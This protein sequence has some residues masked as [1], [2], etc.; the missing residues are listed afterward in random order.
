M[1]VGVAVV[2]LRGLFR[3]FLPLD[4]RQ[5]LVQKLTLEVPAV[6][7]VAERGRA[8]AQSV[9]VQ[10]GGVAPDDLAVLG[11]AVV[12]EKVVYLFG[13]LFFLVLQDLQ[14]DLDLPA[15]LR[16]LDGVVEEVDQ[17]LGHPVWV[18]VD[19]RVKVFL[20]RL[21]LRLHQLE[22]PLV[23]Y[24]R[25][26]LKGVLDYIKHVE[27]LAV[28][29]EGLLL[30]LCQVKQVH[31]QV[32]HHERAISHAFHVVKQLLQ[33]RRLVL[34]RACDLLNFL[35][36]VSLVLLVDEGLSGLVAFALLRRPH[37]ILKVV[38]LVVAGHF[39][40]EV[41]VVACV[42][43]R[44]LQLVFFAIDQKAQ[45]LDVPRR[46]E[47]R[48]DLCLEPVELLALEA[49]EGVGAG[50]HARVVGAGLEELRDVVRVAQ[51]DAVDGA[52]VATLLEHRPVLLFL[53]AL[54]INAQPPVLLQ[55][56]EVLLDAGDSVRDALE[57]RLIVKHFGL[58]QLEL[59]DDGV[60]RVLQ[61]VDHH[62]Q[63]DARVVDLAVQGLHY[64]FQLLGGLEGLAEAALAFDRRHRLEEIHGL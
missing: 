32:L 4:G 10:L 44:K 43:N 53:Q 38:L 5:G 49:G 51:V 47:K 23:R 39:L 13:S 18:P 62:V 28:E 9:D 30:N 8:P 64:F 24:V 41:L 54:L 20:A 55:T 36:E 63:E 12:E 59:V 35:A 21:H 17:H 3:F 7:E 48:V 56:L 19:L 25:H 1:E 37:Q 60:R 27:D 45:V 15:P 14:V 31:H 42:L 6:R 22:L 46:A 11:V 29:A 61:V 40:N 26:H 58:K 2:A 34:E 33:R 57:L 50:H 52:G 16:E